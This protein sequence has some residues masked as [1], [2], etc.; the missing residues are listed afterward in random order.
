[1]PD[2]PRNLGATDYDPVLLVDNADVPLGTAQKLDAH[3]RGLKHRAVS[4]LVRNSEGL[5]LLQRRAAGK[6]HSGGLWA[7]ACCSHPRPDESVGKAVQRRLIE[8]MGV[9]CAL[10]PLFIAHYRAAVSNDL[11][12]DEVV[13]VFGGTHD[14][15]MAPNPNEV[16]EWK[17]ISFAELLADQ[18]AHP[19]H[20]AIWFRHYVRGYGDIIEA[21]THQRP[22][23]RPDRD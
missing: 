17:W 7:N 4:A 15:G 12:E 3:R 9:D 19:E 18:T 5:M 16:S 13:H 6:Y 20:Y 2:I 14:G 22:L 8:E 11:V 21:W 23:P 10:Q 1:M